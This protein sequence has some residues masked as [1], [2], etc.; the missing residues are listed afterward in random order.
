MHQLID[1]QIGPLQSGT[2]Q[3]RYQ[4]NAVLGKRPG[5]RTFLATDLA[6][7]PPTQQQAQQ[8]QAQQKQVVI[9]LVLL[10]PDCSWD[11]IRLFEREA[12][13]LKL[14]DH[15]AIPDYL[16]FFEIKT[17]QGAGFAL[18]QT[19]LPAQS[20]QTLVASGRRFSEPQL[21]A[22]AQ[23]MLEVL[24][25]LHQQSPAVIHR[26]IKPSNLLLDE[27]FFESEGTPEVYLVDFGAV[28]TAKPD[29]TLTVVGTYGYMPP[30]QF[31]GRA[32]PA[33]DLYSLGATLIYLATGQHP[34]D[35]MQDNLQIEFE[36]HVQL[37]HTFTQWLRHVTYADLLRRLP[38][39]K[40]AK[41]VLLLP[42]FEQSP[43]A[44]ST[45]QT[46]TEKED[47][48]AVVEPE[49]HNDFF[50]YSTPDEIDIQ[51]SQYRFKSR[52]HYL[53]KQFAKTVLTQPR[54]AKITLAFL[55]YT[56]GVISITAILAHLKVPLWQ[57]PVRLALFWMPVFLIMAYLYL[58][59]AGDALRRAYM[60][61]R[62][63]RCEDGTTELIFS[64]LGYEER[65][66][67]SGALRMVK[68][69]GRYRPLRSQIDFILLPQKSRSTRKL[70]ISGSLSEMQ[71]L[72]NRLS[73]WGDIPIERG[74]R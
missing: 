13:T 17:R 26:D 50:V 73:K 39:A 16:D 35:L 36:P 28:R 41:Q 15:P 46:S 62:L 23:A 5:R 1:K 60:S 37:S 10:G 11:M 45:D 42:E 66:T 18:V 14:L 64:Q 68:V 24:T 31:G 53:G 59:Q 38:T 57:H 32:H 55:A 47:S 65:L 33:S 70:F 4:L 29:G 19:Y 25:Y 21:K 48:E 20:L 74:Q 9:K 12:T 3:P 69:T 63:C 30:E 40:Q 44:P 51:C 7:W 22:I 72:A 8:K 34:A 6:N 61:L 67:L 58:I 56:L 52:S 54:Q 27:S 2:F 43:N 71:W 49:I